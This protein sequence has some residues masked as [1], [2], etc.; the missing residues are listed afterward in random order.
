MER[1]SKITQQGCVPDCSACPA[2][3]THEPHRSDPILRGTV[4]HINTCSKNN[5]NKKFKC[6]E[7]FQGFPLYNLP[8]PSTPCRECKF[9]E[10]ENLYLFC[11]LANKIVSGRKCQ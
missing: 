5:P 6:I 3:L 1:M 7:Y 9:Q 4:I 11:Y 8:S 10:G 2:R